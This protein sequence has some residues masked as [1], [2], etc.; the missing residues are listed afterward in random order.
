MRPVLRT[1]R[2]ADDPHR[3]RALGFTVQ[4]RW[5]VLKDTTLEFV[6][7]DHGSAGIVGWT[8]QGINPVESIDGLA[9]DVGDSP[10]ASGLVPHN[11]GALSLDHVVVTT[12]SF[13]RTSAVL[14]E[15]GL[16]LRRVREAPN[17]VRQGFRRLGQVILELVEIPNAP[18]PAAPGRFWGLVVTVADL[19]GLAARLGSLL[20]PAKDAVQPGRRIATLRPSAGVGPAV[21]FM[22]P[23]P[24]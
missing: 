5:L 10:S 2:L 14:A 24:N 7:G 15:V 21:A 19:D 16:E 4:D 13:D 3:W 1:L 18:D 9:T 11:N 22:T 23:A 20:G 6:E 8:L 12:P 17:G